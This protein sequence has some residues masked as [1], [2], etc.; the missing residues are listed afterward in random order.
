MVGKAQFK[1]NLFNRK[2]GR[3]QQSLS[4]Q[5]HPLL[6]QL[7]GRHIQVFLAEDVQVIGRDVQLCRIEGHKFSL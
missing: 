1:R 2:L 5:H 7:R 3:L 6:D 4:F